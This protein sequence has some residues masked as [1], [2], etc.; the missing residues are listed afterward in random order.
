ML[1]N[2]FFIPKHSRVIEWGKHTWIK[3]LCGKHPVSFLSLE[4]MKRMQVNVA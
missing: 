1:I 2:E 4:E 3:D